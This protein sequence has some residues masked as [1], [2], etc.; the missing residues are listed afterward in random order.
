MVSIALVSFRS[1]ISA[2]LLIGLIGIS[3]AQPPPASSK[4]PVITQSPSGLPPELQ[5]ISE[6][7][8]KANKLYAAKQF[9]AALATYKD[10]VHLAIIAKLNPSAMLS[11]YSNMAMIE[12]TIG[13]NKGYADVLSKIVALDPTNAPALVQLA[14][15]D[16]QE[17][18]YD[19]AEKYAN[20]ALALKSNKNID[21][22]AHFVKGNVAV[23]HQ[24]F[25]EAA[26]EFGLSAKLLPT[27]TMAHFNCGLA[28]AELKQYVAAQK[29]LETAHKLDPKNARINEYLGKLKTYLAALKANPGAAVPPTKFDAAIKQDPHNGP[30]LLGRARVLAKMGHSKEAEEAYIQALLVLTTSFDAHFEA[31]RLFLTDRNFVPAKQNYTQAQHIAEKAGKTID[32][33]RSFGGLAET[34]MQE[35]LSVSDTRG[36][37]QDFTAAETHI[38]KA[39]V[40]EP[41]EAELKGL[42]GRVYEA[43]SRF[44]EAA[45]IYRQML[46]NSPGDLTIYA[47]LANTYKAVRD[48]DGYVKV[49]KEYQALKPDDPNSYEFITE[50]YNQT[51]KYQE[52]ADT[53]RAMQNRKLTNS[54]QAAAKVILGQD[55][56]ELKHPDEARVEFKK[57]LEIIPSKVPAEYML[58]EKAALDTAQR[59]ALKAL[60]GEDAKENKFDSAI[61]YLEE[62]KKREAEMYKS[63][64]QYPDGEVY[65]NIAT[66]YE[67]SKRLDKAM[68][69]YAEMARVLPSDPAPHAE[70]G[71]ILENEKKIDAAAI[72]YKKAAQ[73]NTKDPVEDEIKI[74]DMYQR[75]DMLDKA[76]SEL[77]SI[78]RSHPAKAEVLTAL[79]LIYR[80]TKQDDKALAIYDALYKTN[81]TQG[82]VQDARAACL[83]NLHRNKDAEGVYVQM[84]DRNPKAGRQTYADLAR[85][86]ELEG[87]ADAFLGF[88]KPRFEKD[89]SNSTV[90]GVVYD[91]FVRQKKEKEGQA[92]ISGVIE[93]PN[94]FRRNLLLSY[95]NL[96]QINKH[97]AES[98]DV[99]RRI[100]KENPKDIS[101]WVGLADELDF[102]GMH[103]DANQIYV[104]QIARTDLKP[105]DK[106]TLQYKLATRYFQ[107][108]KL[109]DARAAF[110]D[111][112]NHHRVNYDVAM[113]LGDLIEKTG[114]NDEAIAF[115][116]SLLG[117]QTYI[118][119]VRL[120]IHNRLGNIYEKTNKP[121]DAI[122]QFNEALKLD[123]DDAIANAHLKKLQVNPSSAPTQ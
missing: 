111:L 91:E 122:T 54:V 52:A 40:L 9:E 44:K 50:M 36:R 15:A 100:A 47:R 30:A 112:F 116:T 96:L 98:L 16:S 25:A 14:L 42:L 95:A 89:P 41:K 115:Y 77:E 2:S 33:A 69:E 19:E 38:K 94:P 48:V 101:A 81:P 67:Q 29:E 28:L 49:W 84:I 61:A 65:K 1:T 114:T 22:T 87:K 102:N 83:I 123:K 45:D 20:K 32:S 76:L 121:A 117:I 90:M 109:K 113:R 107:Q 66:F 75:N 58:G 78:R 31:G 82:W 18:Q 99:Y 56:I 70:M 73:L 55:L 72:E 27:N 108:N 53:L 12:H 23:S 79:A 39:I 68:A 51:G 86:Y 10:F 88:I 80:R 97:N 106:F 59:S 35:G 74:S 85:T 60:A 13:D 4:N 110:Q 3:A 11:A 71:R 5:K 119:Q 37:T 46:V 92:Y 118:P 34:E 8:A 104:D 63:A 7:F 17:H 120:D 21:S 105:D 57:V 64:Q 24:N 26:K 93:K 6:L 62:L 103:D 43:Q